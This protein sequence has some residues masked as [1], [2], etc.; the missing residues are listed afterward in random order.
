VD[1]NVQLA[2]IISAQL[3]SNSPLV[4]VSLVSQQ[5][6]APR[7]DGTKMVV[8]VDGKTFGTIGGSLIEAAAIKES[9]PRLHPKNR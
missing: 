5:G 8:A 4:L 1:E 9:R 3:R 7:H 2:K 6:S